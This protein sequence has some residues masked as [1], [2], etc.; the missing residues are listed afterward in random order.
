MFLGL[1]LCGLGDSS[2]PDQDGKFASEAPELEDLCAVPPLVFE[3]VVP[4]PERADA[5]VWKNRVF[6]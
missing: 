2:L 3:A 1:F 5:E 4:A 6:M